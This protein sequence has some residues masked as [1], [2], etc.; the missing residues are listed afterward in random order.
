[1]EQPYRQNS[2]SSENSIRDRKCGASFGLLTIDKTL[3]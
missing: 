1:L 2:D 3:A